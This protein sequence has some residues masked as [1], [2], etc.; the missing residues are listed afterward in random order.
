MQQPETT[1]TSADPLVVSY[2]A[3]RRAVGV[4]GLML[5]LLLWPGAWLVWG[6]PVQDN[7]SA[8]YHTPARDVFVGALFTMGVFLYC[9]RGHDWIE[10]ASANVGSVSALGLALFP[11]DAGKDP[12][13]AQ[14][15]VGY[16][17]MAFGA[18]L[19]LT[20]AFYS[21]VH[22]PHY[23]WPDWR[24]T[25]WMRERSQAEPVDE[26]EPHELQRNLIYWASGLV[27]LSSMAAMGAYLVM[28]VWLKAYFN[29][30]RFL[31][32]MEWVAL[33]AFAAAWLTKGRAIVADLAVAALV[34]PTEFLKRHA[35]RKQ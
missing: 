21:L 13:E 3:V 34:L 20:L 33:W 19:F 29:D 32:W 10:D 15:W 9:Y 30:Y 31:F 16:L 5:P 17:H 2:L 23:H 11:L 8:Y 25:R 26:L 27:I 12:L 7:M 28:P 35:G 24:W 6:V 4:T 22:F 18:S 14:S 1:A